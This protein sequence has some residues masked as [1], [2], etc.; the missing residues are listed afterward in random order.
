M[1]AIRGVLLVFVSVLLFL[2]FVVTTLFWTLSISLNYENLQKE[3]TTTIRDTIQE[4]FN[5]AGELE[6]QSS[7]IGTY[8]QTNTEYVFSYGDEVTISIPCSVAL[9]GTS[10]I[11][12]EMIKD[13]VHNIY[14]KEYDCNFIDC[15]KKSELPLFLISEKA[16]N[17]IKS[18]LYL[19][20][21]IS[22]ALLVLMFLLIEKKTN[23]PILAG[24]LLAVSSLLFFKIDKLFFFIS[25]E[26][27]MK[28]LGIFFSKAYSVSL[29]L[30]IVAGVLILLGIVL[31]VFKIGF[32][33]SNV[34]S[35]FRKKGAKPRAKKGAKQKKPQ[36][37]K[38]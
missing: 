5:I 7:L 30:L 35:R 2:S 27:A 22:F 10:A 28:I 18:K 4:K 36:K 1:G 6:S 15:F 32:F 8:C 13:I 26:T 37:K 29:K 20:L 16:N 21:A 11:V 24:S 34:F 12:D 23:M 31:K 25:D 19:L 3:A 17:Y 9:Q 33:I 38:K 14:Y